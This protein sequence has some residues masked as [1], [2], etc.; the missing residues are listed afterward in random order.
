MTEFLRKYWIE[1]YLTEKHLTGFDN[2]KV[3]VFSSC[4]FLVRAI[5]GK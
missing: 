3:S 1:E 2:Y 4:V 5:E